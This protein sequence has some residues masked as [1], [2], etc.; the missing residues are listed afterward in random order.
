MHGIIGDIVDW[1]TAHKVYLAAEGQTGERYSQRLEAAGQMAEIEARWQHLPGGF[2]GQRKL[3]K[4]H[5][6]AVA[7]ASPSIS[8]EELCWLAI[9]TASAWVPN[10]EPAGASAPNL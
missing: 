8:S 2:H 4:V 3:I 9:A 5:V 7:A 10:P 1:D 6:Q